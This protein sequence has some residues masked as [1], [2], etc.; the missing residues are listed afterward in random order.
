MRKTYKMCTAVLAMTC[1]AGEAFAGCVRHE[2]MVALR[3][4]AVQQQLMVAALSCNAISRYNKFVV[5]YRSEL[6]ASDKTLQRFF[7]RTTGGIAAY[8]AYKTRLA[9]R[10]S[11]RSIGNSESY[12]SDAADAFD[13]ALNSSRSLEDFVTARPV[14]LDVRYSN[15]TRRG[16]MMHTASAG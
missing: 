14:M 8:H 7:R 9:N 15:C 5:S 11:L 10:S 6:Q 1:M 12:C 2:E 4:A 16:K 3:V 13:T